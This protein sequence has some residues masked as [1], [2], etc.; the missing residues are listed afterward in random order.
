MLTTGPIGSAMILKESL[1]IKTNYAN[2]LDL[3][4]VFVWSVDT[5]DFSGIYGEKYPL[6]KVCSLL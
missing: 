2:F 5:D 4:G 6:L 3:A 1:T